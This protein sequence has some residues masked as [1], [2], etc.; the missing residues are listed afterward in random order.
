[1]NRNILT[2]LPQALVLIAALG[3][4]TS[5]AAKE[6]L[7]KSA[8]S[9]RAPHK[10]PF[11]ADQ[12]ALK[13]LEESWPLNQSKL[14]ENLALNFTHSKSL[15]TN[16]QVFRSENEITS[17]GLIIEY[18]EY[19]TLS[20][21]ENEPALYFEFSFDVRTCYPTEQAK[22]VLGTTS[23][24]L[25]LPSH[26]ATDQ[27]SLKA[28]SY[29]RSVEGG[30]IVIRTHEDNPECIASVARTKARNLSFPPINRSTN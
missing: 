18:A 4:C 20:L 2:G 11:S 7:T 28:A 12:L 10:S 6:E 16:L 3:G 14:S 13:I 21:K 19:R 17:D 29:A 27:N 23:R 30:E 15:S 22:K 25:S 8:A 26:Y 24:L 9:N 5:C 1:M